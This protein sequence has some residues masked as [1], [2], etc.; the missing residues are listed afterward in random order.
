[1]GE[2][3]FMFRKNNELSTDSTKEIDELMAMIEDEIRLEA[4]EKKAKNEIEKKE[5]QLLNQRLDE[6]NAFAAS[7]AVASK[8]KQDEEVA[9]FQFDEM[10]GITE[11]R[12][13]LAELPLENLDETED[14]EETTEADIENI[15]EE[16]EEDTEENLVGITKKTQHTLSTLARAERLEQK[17]AQIQEN[18]IN[19][20]RRLGSP[21][22]IRINPEKREAAKV[23]SQRIKATS[24]ILEDLKNLII[25]PLKA[26]WNAISNIL[27]PSNKKEQEKT[28]QVELQPVIP[29]AEKR[30]DMLKQELTALKKELATH[31]SD[32]KKSNKD[33]KNDSTTKKLLKEIKLKTKTIEAAEKNIYVMKKLNNTCERANQLQQQLS[34]VHS[35]LTTKR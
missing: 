18:E 35:K 29:K 4:A 2:K 22:E 30:H 10:L 3:Q 9:S 17:I 32:L 12:I 1:M 6:L 27:D 23:S 24:T 5:D 34:D 13:Q 11:D 7:N 20:L 15:E 26:I 14:L 16:T 28:V 33:Y 8:D 25:S 19:E 31:I 21:Q